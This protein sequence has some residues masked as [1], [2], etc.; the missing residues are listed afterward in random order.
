MHCDVKLFHRCPELVYG[1]LWMVV[2]D[3]KDTCVRDVESLS[4]ENLAD[5]FWQEMLAGSSLIVSPHRS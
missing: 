3:K 1:A 4:S 2:L 5:V